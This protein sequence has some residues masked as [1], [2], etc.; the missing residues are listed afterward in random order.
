MSKA[1]VAPKVVPIQAA[2]PASS[3]ATTVPLSAITITWEQVTSPFEVEPRK[4]AI[5]GSELAPLLAWLAHET[6]GGYWRGLTDPHDLATALYELGEI[7]R[8]LEDQAEARQEVLLSGIR[9][10]VSS[11]SARLAPTDW[12]HGVGGDFSVT[13]A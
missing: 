9:R 4:F 1:R 6:P 5:T 2:E 8:G 11:L 10:Q 12:R 7:C 13:V 3:K